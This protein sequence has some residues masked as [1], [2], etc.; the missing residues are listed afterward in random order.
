[1][2]TCVGPP[3]LVVAPPLACAATANDSRAEHREQ[4]SP[5]GREARRPFGAATD[6]EMDHQSDPGRSRGEGRIRN[7]HEGGAG[8][9]WAVPSLGRTIMFSPRTGPGSQR[10]AA[11]RPTQHRGRLQPAETAKPSCQAHERRPSTPCRPSLLV[12]MA[13][14]GIGGLCARLFYL[15]AVARWLRGGRRRLCDTYVL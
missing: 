13:S 1:M 12:G 15:L 2:V 11:T 6:P 9:G 4:G 5:G 10:G 7:D 3:W 14:S 8:S